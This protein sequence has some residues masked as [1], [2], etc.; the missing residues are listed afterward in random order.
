MTTFESFEF[1]NP[2]DIISIS[3]LKRTFSREYIEM[4]SHP[5]NTLIVLKGPSKRHSRQETSRRRYID[6]G[7]VVY[8]RTGLGT[9]IRLIATE[10]GAENCG[11]AQRLVAK[12]M[13]V[14]N[15]APLIA[16]SCATSEGFWKALGFVESTSK[17]L[18]SKLRETHI[19]NKDLKLYVRI[20]DDV[21]RSR[22]DH[23]PLP[24]PRNPQLLAESTSVART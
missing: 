14:E 20:N 1:R 9:Y 17:H 13:E 3:S 6:L 22:G 15:N 8:A 4:S 2:K 12:V 19:E 21:P 23:R 5:N 11:V 7:Y 16:M 10:P 18:R 24:P